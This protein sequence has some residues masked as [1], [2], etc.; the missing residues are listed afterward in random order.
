[1]LRTKRAGKL[2][3][4]NSEVQS[5]GGETAVLLIAGTVDN[6]YL[7]KWSRKDQLCLMPARRELSGLCCRGTLELLTSPI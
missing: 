3:P 5:T 7:Q 4:K 6:L 2:H 1:M